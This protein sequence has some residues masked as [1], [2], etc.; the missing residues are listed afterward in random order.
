MNK[1]PNITVNDQPVDEYLEG[2][3]TK[4]ERSELLEVIREHQKLPVYH[5][6][7]KEKREEDTRRVSR[8]VVHLTPQQIRKEYGIM[9]MPYSNIVQNVLAVI[10]DKGPITSQEIS[11][12]M[13]VPIQRVY[14]VVSKLKRRA[15]QFM[16]E[17]V[18]PTNSKQKTFCIDPKH[19]EKSVESLYAHYRVPKDTPR[20]L[21]TPPTPS[22]EEPILNGFKGI[23][24]EISGRVD[25]VFKVER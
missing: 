20:G 2:E 14:D 10:K 6:K 16:V 11:E 21:K 24:L 1:D 4:R 25:V 5:P 12:V 3:V 13:K 9:A 7:P 19:L 8:R 23:K 17:A 18:H 15:P 22:P